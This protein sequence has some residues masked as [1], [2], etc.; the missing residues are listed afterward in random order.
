MNPVIRIALLLVALLA[1]VIAGS[2]FYSRSVKTGAVNEVPPLSEPTE[3]PTPGIL[4]GAEMNP[5][6]AEGLQAIQDN[7]LEEARAS[8][9]RVPEVDPGYLVALRNLGQVRGML[10][11]WEGAR[12]DLERL[13]TIQLDTRDALV[14]L[15]QV[16]YRLGDF[17]AAELSALRALEIDEGDPLLRFDLA[18]YRVAQNRLAEALDTYERAIERDPERTRTMKALERL[19]SLH[20]RHPEIP[21]VHYALAYFARR[22][23]RLDLEIQELEHYLQTDPTGQTANFARQRLAEAL[24]Q[25][26]PQGP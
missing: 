10:G 2:Y 19:M 24:G 18:L 8:L 11:D 16:Q 25:T 7:R 5:D 26:E 9:E 20:D 3:A 14:A 17:D 12:E 4:P 15:G 23:A 1:V 21:T 13:L 6:L 22:L